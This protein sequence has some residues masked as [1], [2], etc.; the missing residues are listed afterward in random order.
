MACPRRTI[1]CV[2]NNAPKSSDNDDNVIIDT[3]YIVGSF[4]WQMSTQAIE[5]VDDLLA[6]DAE[7]ESL[8]R[9]KEQLLGSAAHGDRGGKS[10]PW[11]L[12][13]Y[14]GY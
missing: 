8:R 3:N 13:M 11:L 7:D 4:C 14:A 5:S 12:Y 6:K 10:M 9:Y 1:E 2:P